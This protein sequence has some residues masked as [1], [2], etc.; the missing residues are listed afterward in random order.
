MFV[1]LA[2][3]YREQVQNYMKRLALTSQLEILMKEINCANDFHIIL[4]HRK[5]VE[6][7]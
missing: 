2:E 1:F 5:T 4:N 3:K 7:T 6:L